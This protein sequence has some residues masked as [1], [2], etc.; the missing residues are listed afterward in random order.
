MTNDDRRRCLLSGRH[1]TVGDVVLQTIV[2]VGHRG[3]VVSDH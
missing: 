1:I 2:V 3:S